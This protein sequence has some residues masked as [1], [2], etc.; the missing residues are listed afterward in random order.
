MRKKPA[1]HTRL[2]IHCHTP[3]CIRKATEASRVLPARVSYR[4]CLS[5]CQSLTKQMVLQR[6]QRLLTRTS[7]QA[8]VPVCAYGQKKDR[9]N[10]VNWLPV[11]LCRIKTGEKQGE[12]ALKE[13]EY[14]GVFHVV[15]LL[16]AGVIHHN[17]YHSFW[18]LCLY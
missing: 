9:L 10:E 16:N 8:E 5:A 11:C 12:K 7:D 2:E 4:V 14:R 1:R 3:T 18:S 13:Y 6:T 15:C 17:G